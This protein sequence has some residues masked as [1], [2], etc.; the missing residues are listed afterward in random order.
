M[1][2]KAELIANYSIAARVKGG[3]TEKRNMTELAILREQQR[4]AIM[5]QLAAQK[6]AHEAE[7]MTYA[8]FDPATV[9]Y[10]EGHVQLPDFSFVWRRPAVG[11]AAAAAAGMVFVAHTCARSAGSWWSKSDLCPTC[12]P[13]PLQE[14]IVSA[15]RREGFA[16]MTMAPVYAVNTTQCWHG[17][18]RKYIA[19][20]LKYVYGALGSNVQQVP[21]YGLGNE[22]GGYHLTSNARVYSSR[23]GLSFAALAVMNTGARVSAGEGFPPTFFVDL[24]KNTYSVRAGEANVERLKT[25]SIDAEQRVSQPRPVGPDYFASVMTEQ[26]SKSFQ[27]ELVKQGYV[28]ATNHTLL[29][30]PLRPKHHRELVDVIKRLTHD[31]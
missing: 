13:L 23:F 31:A 3:L 16:V 26:Q 25:A 20:A 14:R 29:K 30:D 18:D 1:Q 15:L 8:G 12:S 6:A 9:K 7:E 21:L 24:A 17:R 28:G 22:N 5:Q 10:K 19:S 2:A 11:A 4:D 27:Q